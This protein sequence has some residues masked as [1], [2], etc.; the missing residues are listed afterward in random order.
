L[1]SRIFRVFA[2]RQ[3]T[4]ATAD[5]LRG[6]LSAFADR[7]GKRWRAPDFLRKKQGD[8]NVAFGMT[9]APGAAI[10][11]LLANQ[12]R[13]ELSLPSHQHQHGGAQWF[14]AYR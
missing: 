10:V 6:A 13:G 1:E 7:K 3:R 12:P 9:V 5:S 11:W 14:V 8:P 4:A 2:N